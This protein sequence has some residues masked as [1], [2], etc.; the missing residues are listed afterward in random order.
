MRSKGF[1]PCRG[2][3][4]FRHL[5]EDRVAATDIL[6]DSL[7]PPE[8][9]F[10]HRFISVPAAR[11]NIPMVL[12]YIFVA[13][14]RRFNIAASATSFPS[15][16][17]AHVAPGGGLP[18]FW[19]DVS[20][21]ETRPILQRDVVLRIWNLILPF[22]ASPDQFIQPCT[23]ESSLIRQANNI[24][25]STR[26]P[27]VASPEPRA[28]TIYP[29]ASVLCLLDTMQWPTG[30][31][32]VPDIDLEAILGDL[33][34]PRLLPDNGFHMILM[35][36]MRWE[37]LSR[38][39]CKREAPSPAETVLPKYFVGMVV[40]SDEFTAACVTDWIVSSSALPMY[41]LVISPPNRH[42]YLARSIP[43]TNFTF[44]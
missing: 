38:S 8:D 24:M 17:L 12:V 14:C 22:A 41:S 44:Q 32:V 7:V 10:P 27:H 9:L 3:E 16:V 21:S 33:V 18:D 29:I 35:T 4:M 26:H 36:W 23:P 15:R 25:E 39:V 43:F 13:I 5:T 20:S 40:R 28:S 1:A 2:T 37:E 6:A 42:S 34:A 19:V 30:F 31:G 11:T